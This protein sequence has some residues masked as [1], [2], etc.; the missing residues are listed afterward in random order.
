MKKNKK[1]TQADIL[2]QSSAKIMK[3][4]INPLDCI[5]GFEPKQKESFFEKLR[6]NYEKFIS[7]LYKKHNENRI[8]KLN[9]I[10]FRN[11]ALNMYSNYY[12]YLYVSKSANHKELLNLLYLYGSPDF[13]NPAS[14]E[15]V[16]YNYY[17]DCGFIAA[18]IDA[19]LNTER[20]YN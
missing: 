14:V 11:E 16:E 4:R 12:K 10:S 1:L 17:H 15:S 13:D 9:V 19:I 6:F 20:E 18:E 5:T 7:Y 2:F 3:N 8:K